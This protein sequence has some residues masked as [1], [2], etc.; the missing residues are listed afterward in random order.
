V[1][2]CI[3]ADWPQ[4]YAASTTHLSHPVDTHR[5]SLQQLSTLSYRRELAYQLSNEHYRYAARRD[6]G[7]PPTKATVLPQR[8]GACGMDVAADGLHGQRCVYSST[9]TKLR[10]DSIEQLLHSTIVGGVGRACRQQHKLP[11]AG[12]TV[13]DLLI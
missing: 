7:L 4:P 5:V 1:L 8:C 11:N 2:L 10:H 3:C 13:P 12:R 6:V 9:H